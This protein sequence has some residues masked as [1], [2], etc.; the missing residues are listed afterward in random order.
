MNLDF[1]GL[2][3]GLKNNWLIRSNSPTCD[4]TSLETNPVVTPTT[5][6]SR[7]LPTSTP[8]PAQQLPPE[9]WSK[10]LPQPQSPQ[11]PASRRSRKG[12]QRSKRAHLPAGAGQTSNQDTA[13]LQPTTP[14]LPAPHL[15]QP[16]LPLLQDLQLSSKSLPSLQAARHFQSPVKPFYLPSPAL[17]PGMF[18][19]CRVAHSCPIPAANGAAS[20]LPRARRYLSTGDSRFSWRI[21]PCRAQSWLLNALALLGSCGQLEG[22]ESP[23]DASVWLLPTSTAGNCCW[24][25]SSQCNLGSKGQGWDLGCPAP[26]LNALA[27]PGRAGFHQRLQEAELRA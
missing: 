26:L 3:P 27:L 6:I 1:S 10:A 2:L 16:R 9:P 19:S 17:S 23:R 14:W 4:F 12:A 15:R 8:Q 7:G 18:K 20:S 24:A 21:P 11:G 5:L 25:A 22:Q 13:P